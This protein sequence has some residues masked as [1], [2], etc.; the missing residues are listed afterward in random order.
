MAIDFKTAVAEKD[1]V[2][3]LLS[4]EWL[5]VA[6]QVLSESVFVSIVSTLYQ[7]LQ[8]IKEM[9]VGN[10]L[11]YAALCFLAVIMCGIHLT[12]SHTRKGWVQL[13]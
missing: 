3:Y 13:S 1:R 6:I 2:Y 11:L 7:S 5:R 12:F 10:K 8:T 4:E 9:Y